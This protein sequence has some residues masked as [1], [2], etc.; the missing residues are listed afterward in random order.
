[1]NFQIVSAK[2]TKSIKK[3]KVSEKKIGLK[4]CRLVLRQTGGRAKL[5]TAELKSV[6]AK[7][8]PGIRTPFFL[9]TD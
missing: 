6:E 8:R 7:K 1:L 5:Q 4:L 2:L 3:G 9:L